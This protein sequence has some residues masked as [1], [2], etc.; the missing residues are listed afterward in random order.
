M[1]RVPELSDQSDI[2][3][4]RVEA[5]IRRRASTDRRMG[6]GWMIVPILPLLV[7]IA[8]LAVLVG[9]VISSLA[10][11][12]QLGTAVSGF[13]AIFVLYLFTIFALYAVLLLG[14]L[15]F[16]YLIDRRN[17][18]FKRQQLLFSAISTYL[19]AIKSSTSHE[20]I[21]RLMEFSEDLAF[22]E[23]DRPAGLWAIT[24]L[25]ATPIVVLMVAYN[26]TQDLRKHEELQLAFQQTLP[27]AFEEAG[28]P[29]PTIPSNRSHNRDPMLCVVLTA[30]TAGIFW[31][32]WFYTLLSDY[33]EH[34]NDQA[35]FEDRILASIKPVVTC[36]SCAG[37]IPQNVKF[38]PL[39][40]A[41]Q[42]SGNEMP[43]SA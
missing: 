39:C 24:S 35:V 22:E 25:F 1:T 32:Y 23:G 33:N 41:A 14:A 7:T 3:L 27:L 37:S 5:E 40:G 13:A 26:L 17:R 9:L 2:Q 38:C 4:R 12:Q 31:V 19:L 10:N 11:I 43:T 34:F 28:L 18:H 20:Q 8:V 42:S 6:Y 30:I 21:A 15:A 16:Y 29:R 36:A